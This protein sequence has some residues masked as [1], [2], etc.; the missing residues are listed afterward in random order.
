[1]PGDRGGHLVGWSPCGAGAERAAEEAGTATADPLRQ[2]ARVCESRRGPVGLRAGF[3]LA[4]YPTRTT[5]GER[6]RGELQR[7]LPRRVPE[8]ELVQ[9]SG[10]REGEDRALEAG[11]QPGA[12]ALG[13]RLSHPG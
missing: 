3:A 9:R 11:L 8:R 12:A 6:L 13:A 7:A 2:R 5:D 4:H 1:M 10:R